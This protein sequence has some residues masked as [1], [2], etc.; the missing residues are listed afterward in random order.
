MAAQTNTLVSQPHQ[1]FEISAY[2]EQQS[3]NRG[4]GSLNCLRSATAGAPRALTILS[5][6]GRFRK[7]FKGSIFIGHVDYL[8]GFVLGSART[9]IVLADVGFIGPMVKNLQ[10]LVRAAD[11]LPINRLVA[12]RDPRRSATGLGSKCRDPP[13]K[14]LLTNL[15]TE[16][17]R[18]GLFDPIIT[19]GIT[20]ENELLTVSNGPAKPPFVDSTPTLGG[21]SARRNSNYAA[22]LISQRINSKPAG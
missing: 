14:N 4:F 15:L 8:P 3:T 9:D 5:L 18:K 19:D 20:R 13:K 10:G 7:S 22:S 6:G 2:P 16:W 12:E 11:A 17:C 1:Y 21:P